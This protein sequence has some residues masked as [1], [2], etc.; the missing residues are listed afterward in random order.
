MLHKYKSKIIFGLVLAIAITLGITSSVNSINVSLENNNK[1]ED[2]QKTIEENNA[3]WN[4]GKTSISDYSDYEIKRLLGAKTENFEENPNE[5]TTN[6]NAPNSFDWRDV[7]GTDYTTPVKNQGNCGS[8][9]GFGVISALEVYLKYNAD[10]LYDFDLSEGHLFFCGGG[11]C[12]GGWWPK[13][14]LSRLKNTGVPDETCLPYN[15]RYTEC[16]DACEDWM[17][18]TVKISDFRRAYSIESMKESIVTYGPLVGTLVV[19]SDLKYYNGGIYE[20]VSGSKLGGHCVSIVG[21][22]DDPGYWICKNSW[23]A[24]WGEDGYFRIKYK[25]CEIHQG[26]YYMELGENNRP[27]NPNNFY[28][29][30]TG[31]DAGESIT[32]TVTST[33]PDNDGVYY[34][35]DWDDGS[36]SGW[37]PPNPS[38][39]PYEVSHS[40]RTDH[41][42]N[43]NVKVKAMDVYGLESGW[44]KNVEVEIYNNPPTTPSLE[45]ITIGENEGYRAVS[46]DPDFDKLYYLFDWGDSTDSGWQG[47]FDSGEPCE[48]EHD[49]ERSVRVKARDENGADSEWSESVTSFKTNFDY[50][51]FQR[52]IERILS[53]S[54]FKIKF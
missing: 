9:V 6:M 25:E 46:S 3:D 32:F 15:S 26:A 13:D 39:E 49:Y 28:T 37:M 7:Y 50:S 4:A 10:N 41:S 34:L 51:F 8:C 48:V 21:Y 16:N 5:E 19:Y 52:L 2:L 1:I 31:V 12:N 45:K 35:F 53:F 11:T 42:D 20:H 54:F 43:Y 40:W 36:N 47:A 30:I 14:A 17:K 23:G 27:N 38:G 22:N 29:N 18:K 33:D 44:S 24:N